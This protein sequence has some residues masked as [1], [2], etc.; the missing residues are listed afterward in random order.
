MR[1][2]TE[3]KFG[4]LFIK[5]CPIFFICFFP[6]F[7]NFIFYQLITNQILTSHN[8]LNGEDERD[9]LVFDRVTAVERM[10]RSSKAVLKI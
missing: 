4:K 5:L 1:G 10:A 7:L 8:S 2:N 9:Y 6:M 3:F